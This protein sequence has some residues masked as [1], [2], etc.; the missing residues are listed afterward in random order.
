MANAFNV[1]R[2][3]VKSFAFRTIIKSNILSTPGTILGSGLGVGNGGMIGASNNS[4][5]TRGGVGDR[6]MT[7]Y[8]TAMQEILD[9]EIT[10][11]TNTVINILTDYLIT[12]LSP[13]AKV[14]TLPK[15]MEAQENYINKAFEQVGYFSD[16][17]SQLR[18]IIYHGSYC[19]QISW[20]PEEAKYE[21]SS[22][23]YPHWVVT[24]KKKGKVN[25]HLIVSKQAKLVEV[26]P[27]SVV[28][29]GS[30]DLNLINNM[31]TEEQ[32]SFNSEKDTLIDDVEFVASSPLYFNI[33]S[34]IKEYLLKDQVISL[35]SIKDLIQPLLL[36]IS[37]DKSTSADT[38]NTLALNVEN[39]INKYADI[40]MI[41]TGQFSIAD[42]MDSLINSVRV[43]PDYNQSMRDMSPID[44]SKITN[45]IQEIRGEQDSNR[46][47]ILSSLG[48]PLDLFTGRSSRWEA[49]KSSERLSSKINSYIKGIEESTK[50]QASRFYYMLTGEEIGV[51]KIQC[52]MFTKTTVEYNAATASADIINTLVRSINDLLNAAQDIIMNNKLIDAQKYGDYIISQLEVIDPEIDSIF[53]KEELAK[54]IEDIQKQRDAER[55]PPQDDFGGGDDLDLG[56]GDS[57]STPESDPILDELA[58]LEG[59]AEEVVSEETETTEVP[60]ED[61]PE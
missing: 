38:S 8:Y 11:I 37:V 19:Y 51:D 45:K 22:F 14:I 53:S 56:G 39:L 17:K 57:E 13:D 43:I 20:N 42:L 41:S 27:D 4:S 18:N 52:N 2:N 9:Y 5:G 1:W 29:I 12:Y 35:L 59:G 6:M 31:V 36:L 28:R 49:V 55:N 24:V 21:K 58:E 3:L 16:I 47:Q 34:K 26:A 60:A 25:S 30:C 44:L 40:S 23:I 10:E 54:M 33:R 48:I 61:L 15:E 50:Y 7:T 46:E 32:T